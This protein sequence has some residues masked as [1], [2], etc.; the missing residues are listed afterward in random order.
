MARGTWN[1]SKW[2]GTSWDAELPMYRPNENLAIERISTQ[3]KIVLA[4]GSKAYF[5]PETKYS[6]E[7]M[8]MQFF[9]IDNDDAFWG[10]M[11]DYVENNDYL[12]IIDHLGTET[13]GKFVSIK[14]VWLTSVED[15]YDLE[16]VFEVQ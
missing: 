10:R 12:K 16:L 7:P 4:D 1:V 8:T 3:N 6:K 5:I 11:E 14:R 2:N 9:E 13:T 15:T